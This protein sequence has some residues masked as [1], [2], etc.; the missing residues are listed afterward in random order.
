MGLPGFFFN[1]N[2]VIFSQLK[3]G[4]EFDL[5]RYRRELTVKSVL[6]MFSALSSIS[7]WLLSPL[8]PQLAADPVS[9]GSVQ[10]GLGL[11]GSGR[12][13]TPAGNMK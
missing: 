1:L 8:L 5:V 4:D 10:A 12:P 7:N 9:R 3:F 6:Q 13:Q 2:K 11:P